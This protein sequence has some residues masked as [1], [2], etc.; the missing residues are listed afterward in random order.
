M[1]EEEEI[2]SSSMKYTGIF[3]FKDFYIFSYTWEGEEIGLN[4][5]E[6][7]YEEKIIGDAKNIL[8]EWTG[9]RKVT[10]YFQFKIKTKFEV[11]KLKDIELVKDGKKEKMNEGQIKITIK[12]TLIRDH[13]GKF[14][15]SGFQ[16]FLR[17][18]YEKW[19][20]PSRIDQFEEK[21]AGD[22][23]DLMEQIKAYLALEGK[24]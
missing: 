17:G 12:G 1:S 15:T 20:I 7:K 19:I 3:L 24:K 16:K 5:S 6:D 2:F 11:S 14:E 13:Q 10:D 8:V 22:C 21:L 9:V 18:Y 23:N 4:I